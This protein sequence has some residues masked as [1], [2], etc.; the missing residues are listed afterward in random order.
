[1]KRAIR[2]LLGR[3]IQEQILEYN[4][5]I[6]AH[7][8][9]LEWAHIY[10]DSIRDKQWMQH[11]SLNIGRWAGSYPFFYVLSR[12]LNDHK[13]KT[14]LEFGLGESSK[15]ISTYLNNYLNE[16][17][18]TIIEQD[19]KWAKA[20]SGR[21]TLSERSLV[22]ILPLDEKTVNGFKVNVYR[23]IEKKITQKYDLYVVDG[24]LG[25]TNYSRYDIVSVVKDLD[26]TDEFVILFDDYDRPGEKET[27][28]ALT[29]MLKE[30]GVN[31][32]V[33]LYVGIKSVAVIGTDKYKYIGT[34]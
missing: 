9:E 13:P 21:F 1:M 11:L 16:T 31:F 24:P 26:A 2:R 4:R 25:S 8:K 34:F 32:S 20:F 17:K 18:H 29:A 28:R 7:T 14:I 3:H 22:E 15:M 19:S 33:G 30:K 10:H 12:I 23:D 6:L 27:F 5:E